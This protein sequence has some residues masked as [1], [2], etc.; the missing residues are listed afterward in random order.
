MTLSVYHTTVTHIG[1]EAALFKEEKMIILFGKDAPESLA[2]YCYNIDVNRVH[3]DILPG[4][5]IQFDDRA[6]RVTAVG[7]VAAKNLAS[8]GHVTIKFNGNDEAELPGTIHV[9]ALALPEIVVGT[10][11]SID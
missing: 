4:M 11:I 6:Y 7:E 1:A 2:D 5:T 3:S 10:H 9:E 8:L